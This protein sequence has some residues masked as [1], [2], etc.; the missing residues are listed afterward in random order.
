MKRI[1]KA[2]ICLL[3]ATLLLSACTV[4]KDESVMIAESLISSIGEPSAAKEEFVT[5]AENYYGTLSEGQKKNVANHDAL[6]AARE[7]IDK[8]K[9]TAADHNK[10]KDREAGGIAGGR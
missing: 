9:T 5:F 2:G 6:I 8:Q 4:K 3:S 10:E 7:A 1:F